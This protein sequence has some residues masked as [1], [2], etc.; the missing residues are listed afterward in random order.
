MQERTQQLGVTGGATPS[1]VA[2]AGKVSARLVSGSEYLP[3]GCPTRVHVMLQLTASAEASGRRAPL[4]LCLV[5]D[6]SGSMEGQPLDYVKR[7]CGHV[8]DMLQES[9]IL[10]IVTF[11]DQVD[12]VMP[13]RR[14]L[15]KALIKEHINRIEPGNTTNIF[16]GLA[17]GAMQVASVPAG[18]YLNRIL[19]LTDGEPTAGI[20]DYGSIVQQVSEHRNRGISVTALGFGPDYNEELMAGV[21]RRSGG[22]YYNITEPGMIPQVFARELESLMTV[23]ARSLH[24]R[25]SFPRDIQCRYLYGIPGARIGD[26]LLEFDLPDLERGGSVTA[27][28][29]LEGGPHVP[30]V[31]RIAR[32]DISFEDCGSGS[33]G[34][35]TAEAVSEFVVDLAKVEAGRNPLVQQELD[36]HLASRDL[37]KTMMGMRTQQITTSA[38]MLELQ[39]AHT[40]LM[41][42]GRSAQAGEVG[43]AIQSLQAGG[44]IQKTLMGTVLNL[45]LGRSDATK[46]PHHD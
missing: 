26:R 25:V 7:A 41:Q 15:N 27:L 24:V 12:V 1:P 34:S 2:Q 33:P 8:V 39:R 5:I 44:E 17:A 13:A 16:D 42:A 38:A 9:D 32:A 14:V 23:S 10:S 11:E 3:A 20:K 46:E 19:L 37:E 40:V 6:R 4:N 29:E 36:L 28:A 45:D 22:N 35:V 21:A 43:D 18:G 30:G 31:F